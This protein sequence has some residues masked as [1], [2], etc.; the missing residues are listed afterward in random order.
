M[1]RFAKILIM[2][3]AICSPRLTH[4]ADLTLAWDAPSDGVATG[5]IIYYGAAP[6]SYSRQVN[7]GNTTSYTVTDLVVG[8]TYYFVVRAYEATGLRS[9]PSGEVSAT[10]AA[11]VPPVVTS[12]A[13]TS[14]VA[15]PQVT[16]TS[17][18]WL[19]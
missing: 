5:Y 8:T 9:D 18:T 2:F 19:A 11:S 14:N 6:R 1:P 12:L 16:G 3:V 15:P 4:A 10:T 7:V 17:V 13:L